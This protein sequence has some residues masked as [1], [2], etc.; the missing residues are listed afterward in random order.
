[1]KTKRREKAPVTKPLLKK[2]TDQHKANLKKQTT[3]KNPK[4]NP[5]VASDRLQS[6]EL[7]QNSGGAYNPDDTFPQ[8]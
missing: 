3:L 8:A 4:Q 1:M 2:L 7:D 5:T 6:A